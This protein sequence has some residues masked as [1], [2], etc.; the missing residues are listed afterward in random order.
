MRSTVC[1]Y[2]NDKENGLCYFQT[3]MASTV[4]LRQRRTSGVLC[5]K[6][7]YTAERVILT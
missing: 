2:P 1:I 7:Y 4:R 5:D 6:T 3:K